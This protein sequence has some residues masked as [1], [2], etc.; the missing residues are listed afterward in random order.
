MAG[1]TD[2]YATN[3]EL[4]VVNDSRDAY[5]R[6]GVLRQPD[7]AARWQTAR[8][9]TLLH[10]PGLVTAS[11]AGFAV[12]SSLDADS[13]A[14]GTRICAVDALVVAGD[15]EAAQRRNAHAVI[16]ALR[17]ELRARTDLVTALV[18][19]DRPVFLEALQTA[20]AQVFGVN[21]TWTC[22]VDGLVPE[23]LPGLPGFHDDDVSPD[24]TDELLVAVADAYS[25]YRSHYNADSRIATGSVAAS[26]VA[27]VE[28][29]VRAG[30]AVA[31]V[32]TEDGSLAAFETID[33]HVAVNEAIGRD[34]IGE[35]AIGGVVPGARLR[36]AYETSLAYGIARLRD[37]GCTDI[38]FACTADNFAVQ[39]TWVRIG[40]WRLRRVTLRLHWWLDA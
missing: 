15:D 21:H 18:D 5:K 33:P 8:A 7:D 40:T 14:L 30:G 3:P 23:F 12:A 25:T 35:L 39:A 24:N 19:L 29:H 34:A 10:S 9:Q 32:R 37:L 20:G 13:A 36:G 28:Q 22:P 6:L 4:F 11:G 17:D 16:E 38:V 2:T 27:A 31:L 1:L 26:Y